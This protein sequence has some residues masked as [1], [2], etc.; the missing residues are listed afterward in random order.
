MQEAEEYLLGAILNK[1]EMLCDVI[2]IIT[3][4]D[5]LIK[6]NKVIYDSMIKLFTE[7]KKIDVVT[8]ATAIKD[9]GLLEQ[10]G[11]ISYLSGIYSAY[12]FTSSIKD[13]AKIVKEESNKRKLIQI[14]KKIVDKG[15]NDS[16]K[17][18]DVIV[19][20]EEELY[21]MLSSKQ[22]SI[23]RVDEALEETMIEIETAYQKGGALVG[24]STGFGDID[25]LMSGLQCQD[26]IIIAARP[27]M[28]KTTLAI[29]MAT[30]ISKT[31]TVAI[32][33]LEM[34]TS[35]LTKKILS[36]ETMIRNDKIKSGKL[37]QQEW[38]HIMHKS[39]NLATRKLFIDDNCEGTVNGIKAKC[40]KL[41]M[42]C[43]LDVVII[44]YLQLMSAKAQSREQEISTI[45]RELKQM[46]KELDVTVIAL[47][48]LSRACEARPNKRPMLS[49]LRE[50]GA[51]EQDAD[52]VMFLYRDEYYNSATEDKGITEIIFGKNRNGRIGTIKVAWL[53]E[54]QKFGNLERR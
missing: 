14:G 4:D 27:S 28:G 41:K 36:S 8:L 10:I 32:F 39:N 49:D 16:F 48:Q 23:K 18:K 21:S 12:N 20:V 35:Q 42:Q 13:Y 6:K 9:I 15:S 29:N 3:G 53:P 45:S 1:P 40:K 26:L 24:I 19:D 37:D 54:Y 30:N 22:S 25:R 2:D 47:S 38:E 11:G 5:F 52:I 7:D 50:S 44:D 33:S 43:G 31:N 17:S 34:S 51:I 46:A